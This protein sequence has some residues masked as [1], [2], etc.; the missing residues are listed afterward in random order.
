M[1][2]LTSPKSKAILNLLSKKPKAGICNPFRYGEKS[3]RLHAAFLCPP[4]STVVI[5][6]YS[7][8]AGLFGQPS[9]LAAPYR[10]IANPLNPVARRFATMG[11]GCFLLDMESPL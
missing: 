10:G 5:R 3:P 7:V 6:A 1:K 9:R 2:L 8:M 4:F 11:G